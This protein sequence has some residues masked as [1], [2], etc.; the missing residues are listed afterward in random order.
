MKLIKFGMFMS[1]LSV[2]LT[3]LISA[4]AY[5]QEPS[6]ED[7]EKFQEFLTKVPPEQ[8]EKI[9][10]MYDI[11]VNH[12]NSTNALQ[13]SANL[14][15]AAPWSSELS[16]FPLNKEA[17]INNLLFH[18]DKSINSPDT[19]PLVKIIHQQMAYQLRI[20]LASAPTN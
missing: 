6:K 9:K 8:R 4:S 7:K 5:A 10:A 16:G 1:L 13:Y 17:L 2:L 18:L 11:I 3:A 20:L 12:S 14:I 15:K 19:M